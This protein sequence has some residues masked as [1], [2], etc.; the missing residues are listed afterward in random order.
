M[1]G[2]DGFINE[3]F[4]M[5]VRDTCDVL[6]AG[7]GTAGVVAALAAARNGAKTILV[8]ENTFFGGAMLAGGVILMGFY[9]IFKPYGAK[10]IQL[11]RGIGD[12]LRVKLQEKQGSTGFYEEVADPAHESMGLHADREVL[13]QVLLE[14]LLKAGVIIF[15]KTLVVDVILD[16]KTIKG[17]IIE[18]KSGREAILA[19]TVIDATGNA[20]VAYRS[21]VPCV[22]HPER[23]SGGM[24]FGLGKINFEKVRQYAEEKKII[25]YLG[26]APKG[27]AG[28][29]TITRIGFVWGQMDE[30]RQFVKDYCCANTPCIISNKES[31]ATMINGVTLAFD[32]SSTKELSLASI[33][34]TDSCFKMA[35]LL[36][37]RVPGFENSFIDWI[38]PIIG[39]RFVR[40]VVCD[41]D[42]RQDDINGNVIP[43]DTIG[44]YGTQDAHSKG[45]DIKGGGYYGIPYRALVPKG[46]ENL[47]V[48]GKMVSSDWVVWMS[49]RLTGACFLQGQAVG[50]AAAMAVKN[51]VTV[52]NLN[53]DELRCV[54]EKDGVYLG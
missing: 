3:S 10:P 47:L 51:G 8:E 14:M 26:Y 53:T 28:N 31:H 20:T 42:I 15:L 16:D 44:L 48:A 19:K 38:S 34:L 54:L 13:P 11:V 40:Q 27:G 36:R 32:T 41:Y 39:I 4:E 9:N 1:S 17:V 12:E 50:T 29:D 35:G 46:I 24:A 5:P 2:N 23:Q 43:K 37:D 49:T 21:G 45:Y 25:H 22:N 33:K 7:G 6:V 30:F 52:R 18:S